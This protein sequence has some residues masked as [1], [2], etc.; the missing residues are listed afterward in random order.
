MIDRLTAKNF[1]ANQN[2]I[3]SNISE[4]AEVRYDNF[5]NKYPM[6]YNRIPLYMIA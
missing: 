1:E 2:R 4:P 3:F 5:V 6:L